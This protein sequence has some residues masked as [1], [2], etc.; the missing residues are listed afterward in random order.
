MNV[1]LFSQFF[2]TTKGGGE[3]VFK[4]IAKVLSENG[5]RVWVVTNDVKNESYEESENLRIV[6][7]K[8]HLEYAGG[9]PPSFFDNIKYSINA[10]FAGYKIAKK[11][12]IE[13]IHSNNFAPVLAGS[14][15]S[16]LAGIPHITTIHDV[17][18][19]YGKNFWTEWAKQPGTSQINARLVPFFEKLMIRLKAE[20]IHTVSEATKN[21]IVQLGAKKPVQI[22]PNCILHKNPISVKTNSRQF[23]FI[24]R[25]VFYKNVQVLIR[26][27]SIV[28]E[29]FPDFK[30]IVA[31]D[32]PYRNM[33]EKLAEE[34]D[35]NEN[36]EF[37]GYVTPKE[38]EV[39]IAESN[40]MLFPS[41]IEGFGLVMLEAF[42]QKKAVIASD[43]PPMSEIIQDGK[44]G[45]LLD[46]DNEKSWA[47]KIK[48][49]IKDHDLSQSMGNTAYGILDKKYSTRSFYENIIKMYEGILRN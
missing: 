33:L 31:G 7:V 49:M 41:K 8:P 5:H 42:Q 40:A 28:S 15:L 17:F 2:S 48:I 23:V 12:K 25:L 30:I 3:Y 27:A 47:E 43:I 11:E 14:F 9:I 37:R 13:I 10:L 19:S 38:K 45:F 16:M 35:V 22:I 36:I 26:A 24:G 18:S 4:T 21:D 6:R 39:V 29:E 20:C 32:G 46:A 1:L 34:L 44:N